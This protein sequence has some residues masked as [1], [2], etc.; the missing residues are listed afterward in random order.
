MYMYMYVCIYV[1]M[2]VFLHLTSWPRPSQGY[3]LDRGGSIAVRDERHCTTHDREPGLPRAKVSQRLSLPVPVYLPASACLSAYLP[4]SLLFW[5]GSL[6]DFC[7]FSQS[8][9]LET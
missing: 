1:C 8:L 6:L 7:I 2:Y 5:T 4:I 9:Y 3:V